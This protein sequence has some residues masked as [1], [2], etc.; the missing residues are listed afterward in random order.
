MHRRLDT[1]LHT[2]AGVGKLATTNEG[3]KLA[4]AVNKRKAVGV[5]HP[6]SLCQACTKH[7]PGMPCTPLLISR[8]PDA[9]ARGRRGPIGVCI[10][11]VLVFLQPGRNGTQDVRSMG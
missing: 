11:G 7:A 2:Q 1:N 4:G 8:H 5:P 3:G 10:G 9:Y 6:P